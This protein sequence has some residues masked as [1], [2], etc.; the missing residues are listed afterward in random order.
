MIVY[1]EGL[2]DCSGITAD[3]CSDSLLEA[4]GHCDALKLKADHDADIVHGSVS[5]VHNSL[6]VAHEV[7]VVIYDADENPNENH[8]TLIRCPER[9]PNTAELKQRARKWLKP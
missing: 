8:S 5:I 1:H 2:V 6:P 3:E 9:I 4:L 7:T